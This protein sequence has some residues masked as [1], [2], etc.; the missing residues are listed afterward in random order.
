MKIGNG[1]DGTT[2]SK[3]PCPLCGSHKAELLVDFTMRDFDG[4]SLDNRVQIILCSRCGFVYNDS[5]VNVASLEQFYENDSLY[6]GDT[7]FG[8]GGMTPADMERYSAYVDF[9]RPIISRPEDGDSSA[10]REKKAAEVP[11]GDMT[12]ADVGCGKGG[13]LAFLKNRGFIDLRG[14][15]ID[16][17][18]VE[19]ASRQF[20]LEITRGSVYG[21]PFGNQEVD[22][23]IYNNVLEHLYDLPGALAEARR[24]LKDDGMVFV[25]V[26]DAPRYSE[27]R[28]F[29][30]F[31]LGMR[32]HINHFGPHHLS[33]FMGNVGFTKVDERR[34]LMHNSFNCRY[35]SLCG[36]FRKK[37]CSTKNVRPEY[38]DELMQ[39]L[40]RYVQ[41]ETNRIASHGDRIRDLS[42]SGR[43]VYVW[44]LGLEFFCLYSLS[45]LNQCNIRC[46]VDRNPFKQKRTVNHLP[47]RGPECLSSAPQDGA[48][49]ITS[50]FHEEAMLR[51]LKD[52]GFGGEIVTLV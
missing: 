39:S 47:I 34:S 31:W 26:P 12:I 30:F 28:V 24:V 7:S 16:P 3:R 43:P 1:L 35:P 2:T 13:F 4:V 27:G 15:E 29:D 19:A 49:V 5:S 51:Y 44:G 23:I 6:F 10:S 17:K 46:L 32:E 52:I 9:L 25:E 48:V 40:G 33:M 8:T 21:L 38:D 42:R 18:C 45:E 11:P 36:L 37:D 41:S 50:V 20:G 22:L 14:V